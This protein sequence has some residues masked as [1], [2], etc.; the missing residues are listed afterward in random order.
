MTTVI[1]TIVTIEFLDPRPRKSAHHILA[2][3][4]RCASL[5]SNAVW[6]ADSRE[7]WVAAEIVGSSATS[8]TVRVLATKEQ[9]TVALKDPAPGVA[10]AAAAGAGLVEGSAGR[11]ERR[12]VFPAGS[13]GNAGV[14]DLISLPHLHEA[15]LNHIAVEAV[16]SVP[17]NDCTD[18]NRHLLLGAPTDRY[19]RPRIGSPTARA[20]SP[21]RDAPDAPPNNR[22]RP[23]SRRSRRARRRGGS[24]R[25]RARSCSRSTRSARC[26]TSTTTRSSRAMRGR[27]SVHGGPDVVIRRDGRHLAVREF[28]TVLHTSSRRATRGASRTLRRPRRRRPAPTRRTSRRPTRSRK[29]PTSSGSRS[30]PVVSR[31]SQYPVLLTP[32][33]RLVLVCSPV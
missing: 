3:P 30:R 4:E 22:S 11:L 14:E 31:F 6:L 2:F 21:P 5:M 16:R 29:G 7:A 32:D 19:D 1:A 9:Q 18:R 23:Y 8:V 33:L 20:L 26:R 15:R 28:Q 25:T 24:T 27:S 10:G 17:L 12:N 13:E